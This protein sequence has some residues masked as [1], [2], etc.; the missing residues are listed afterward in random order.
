MTFA[1]LCFWDLRGG[2][3]GGRR[4]GA[5]GA[6]AVL[7]GGAVRGNKGGNKA[8]VLESHTNPYGYINLVD[9]VSRNFCILYLHAVLNPEDEARVAFLVFPLA[10]S[11]MILLFPL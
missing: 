8:T 11:S 5:D 6:I 9:P 4:R 2:T 3:T 1:L 7:T 10:Y